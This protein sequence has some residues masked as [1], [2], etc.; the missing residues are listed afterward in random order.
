[1]R[2][3]KRVL[4]YSQCY[5]VLDSF[6]RISEFIGICTDDNHNILRSQYDELERVD[7]STVLASYLLEKH[8]VERRI[9]PQTII[10]PF[11]LNRS[12]KKAV[13]NALQSQV[14]II[15]GPPG[16]GKTQTILNIIANIICQNKTVVVVSNNNSA[17]QNVKDKLKKK[18]LDFLCAFLGSSCN[19]KKFIELQTGT[20][21]NM[22]NWELDY[23]EESKLKKDIASLTNE[24]DEKLKSKNRIAEIKQEKSILEVEQRYFN[25]YYNSLESHVENNKLE[26]LSSENLLLLLSEYEYFMQ[27]SKRLSFFKK[28]SLW[29]RYNRDILNIFKEANDAYLSYLQKL[30]YQVKLKELVKEENDLDNKLKLYSYEDKMNKLTEYSVSLFKHNLSKRY[31]WKNGRTVFKYHDLKRNYKTVLKEYPVILSTTYAIKNSL[32]SNYIFDYLIVDESSQVDL[33]TGALALS[34]AKNVVIVGDLKQLPNV[35]KDEEK[36]IVDQLWNP[37]LGGEY[38]FSKH[39]LL[40]SAVEVWKD[41][42]S[43]LLREHYRCHPKIINFCNQKFYNGELI[44]MTDNRDENPLTLYKT[45]KGNHKRYSMNQREIDVIKKEVISNFDE[46]DYSHIGVITPYNMQVDA[47]K[48][49]LPEECKIATVHKFQGQEKDVIILSTVDNYIS[50][51]V[52][53]PHMLNVAVSRA[54]KSLIVVTS[55]NEQNINKNYSSLMKYISYNNFDII[56]SHTYSVFDLLYKEYHEQRTVFLNKKRKVSEFDSENIMYALLEKI[57][58]QNEF[59]G[60]G[61]SCHVPLAMIIKNMHVLTIEEQQFVKNPLTHTDFLLFDKMDKSPILAI[62]VDGVKYHQEGSIQAQ[63]D[64]K[65]DHIFEECHIPLLRL[66]TDGSNEKERIE[67]KLRNIY[68][69][70]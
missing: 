12:Q 35:I 47:L 25:E 46:N 3:D 65:K 16:T 29:F 34:C 10:Y 44:I 45:V 9:A 50:E 20:Y 64:K 4:S 30:F 19:K 7:P 6:K 15:Q 51:F 38:K 23:E 14:S 8:Q 53:D 17:T 21:P 5:N 26:S 41:A 36:K 57:L 52:D 48:K 33:V 22:E 56:D 13:E 68:N 32:D 39:S 54:V 58:N 11:G 49:E 69:M 63:R 37:S 66:R 43:V 61:F 31:L 18:D 40:S 70:I 55:G 60:I 62:E 2:I 67:E 42:P 27:H 1:M 28:V 59:N 24:L